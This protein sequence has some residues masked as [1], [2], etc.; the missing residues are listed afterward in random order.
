[1][2]S[3]FS[4]I[5]WSL[6][7]PLL[8]ISIQVFCLYLN[9]V[10]CLFLVDL[11]EFFIYPGYKSFVDL[12]ITKLFSQAVACFFVLL[13]VTSDE[14]KFLTLMKSN[15]SVSWC[16]FFAYP[17]PWRYFPVFSFRNLIIS[18]FTFWS[19]ICLELIFVY[20]VK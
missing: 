10:I 13:M 3:T 6:W 14:Q 11:F 16:F 12:C 5:Y 4:Y 9:W 8:E 1:M 20:D 7:Y 18:V 19:M 2:L 17:K 15:S